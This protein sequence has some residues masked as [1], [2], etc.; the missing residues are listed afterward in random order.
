VPQFR[1][2]AIAVLGM[3]LDVTIHDD[4]PVAA[5]KSDRGQM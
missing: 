1:L 5:L 3:D 2:E 4:V